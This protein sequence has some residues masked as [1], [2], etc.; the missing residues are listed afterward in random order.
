MFEAI[1][2]WPRYYRNFFRHCW[3]Q[4]S[5]FR[6]R[7]VAAGQSFDVNFP[8]H[9]L[10]AITVLHQFSGSSLRHLAEIKI[11]VY[12]TVLDTRSRVSEPAAM[13]TTSASSKAMTFL[14]SNQ[15]AG[16]EIRTF[17]V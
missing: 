6:R 15:I 12:L 16:R 4:A 1:P 5:Q 7:P 14:S 8:W 2:V 17:D 11:C 9:R 13:D 3:I 10:H